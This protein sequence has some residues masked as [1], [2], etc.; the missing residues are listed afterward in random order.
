M[1]AKAGDVNIAA[2]AAASVFR[3]VP[4]R[5]PALLESVRKCRVFLLNAYQA[6]GSLCVCLL[7]LAMWP[8]LAQVIFE[9]TCSSKAIY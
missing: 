1:A 6:L 2:E 9:I 7:S 3:G 8:V 5:L 4:L